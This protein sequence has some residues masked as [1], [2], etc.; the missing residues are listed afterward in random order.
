MFHLHEKEN[1]VFIL[2]IT[3]LITN[4]GLCCIGF[5]LSVPM[6]TLMNLY[7]EGEKAKQLLK[8]Y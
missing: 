8:W 6:S 3:S 5:S 1:I 2:P 4:L 7:P